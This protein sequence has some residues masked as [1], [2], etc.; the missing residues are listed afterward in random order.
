[1]RGRGVAAVVIAMVLGCAACA[2]PAHAAAP[3]GLQPL[4]GAGQCFTFAPAANGFP[5]CSPF[6]LEPYNVEVTPDGR[7]AYV[8]S[9]IQHLQFKLQVYGRDPATG[10]MTPVAGQGGCIEEGASTDCRSLRGISNGG[11]MAVSP[12]SNVLYLAGSNGVAVFNRDPVTSE[13]TQPTGADG[14][15]TD[16]TTPNCSRRDGAVDTQGTLMGPRDLAMA[17]DGAHLFVAGDEGITVLARPLSGGLKQVESVSGCVDHDGATGT[18]CRQ[19]DGIPDDDVARAEVASDGGAVYAV[20]SGGH[21]V[22]ALGRNPDFD[23]LTQFAGQAGC[24]TSVTP[25]PGSEDCGVDA[26]LAGERA[27]AVTPG[28]AGSRHLYVGG[29]DHILGYALAANGGLGARTGCV[30]DDGNVGCV[31]IGAGGRPQALVASPDGA[32]IYTG[33][34]TIRAL[35][36]DAA[37]G[38][39][40]PVA[41]NGCWRAN[42]STTPPCGRGPAAAANEL[43]ISSDGRH[44]VSAGGIENGVS[45][46]ATYKRDI[47]GP[48]CDNGAASIGH[49]Q[50]VELQLVCRDGEGDDDAV[51]IEVVTPPTGGTFAPVDPASGRYRFGASADFSGQTSV[52]FRATANGITTPDATFTIDVAAAPQPEPTPSP[53]PQPAPVPSPTPTPTPTPTPPRRITSP[54]T[55]RWAFAPTFTLVRQLVVSQVPGDG[56]VRV[57]CKGRGCPFK[58]KTFKPDKRRRVSLTRSF[59]NRRLGVKTKLEI[60]I[61]APGAIGKI[62]TYT[63]RPKRAPSAS[64]RCL[65]VGSSKPARRCP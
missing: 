23:T 61:T 21:A 13:V 2:A 18:D 47:A 36:R 48:V 39:L 20:N 43:A 31:G 4:L 9:S 7:T 60:R 10:V 64:A 30:D 15:F 3:G 59:R 26:A 54:I 11:P 44:L 52:V 1:M 63:M 53:Q 57:S 12:N 50:S 32:Q 37:T 22:L 40:T 65:A 8:V 46:L 51:S 5:A 58:A 55:N 29:Q 38:L 14:C 27:L 17:P 56:R 19:A 33:G 62:V 45:Q 49:S 28:Q 6:N 16:T 35:N 25:Q 41:V 24:W 34:G 42:V